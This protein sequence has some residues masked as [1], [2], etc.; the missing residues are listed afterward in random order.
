MQMPAP[1]ERRTPPAIDDTAT[2]LAQLQAKVQQQEQ[3]LAELKAQVV[4]LQQ[5]PAATPALPAAAP[6]TATPA[7]TW[8]ARLTHVLGRFGKLE[9]VLAG[10]AILVYAISRFTQISSFPL[11]FFADEALEVV[12]AQELLQRGFRDEKGGLLPVFFNAYGFQV[13]LVSV[14]FHALTSSL[15]GNSSDVARLTSACVTLTAAIAA[16]LITKLILKLRYWWLVILVLAVTPVWF[17]HSRTAF[18]T[19]TMVSFYSWFLLFYLLYRYRS[20]NFIVPALLFA[21]LTFYSYGNG[22]IVIGITG[23]LLLISDLPYHVKH[24][25]TNLLGLGFLLLLAVP[26]LRWRQQFPEVIENQLRRVDSFMVRPGPWTEKL[27][28]FLENYWRD[29][30]N[31]DYW[32]NPAVSEN[33]RHLL[34]GYAH[35]PV[36]ALPFYL[37]G[38]AWS[39]W[40]MA[41][42]RRSPL[43]AAH[44]AIII[45][46]LAAPVGV[47]LTSPGVTRS[48]MFVLPAAL[49]ITLGIELVLVWLTRFL[50]GKQHEANPAWLTPVASIALCAMLSAATLGMLR[51][52]LA[53]GPLWYS[54]YGLYGVQWGAQ[55]IFAEVK[56]RLKQ[57]PD[58]IYLLTPNWA[59][60]TDVFLRFFVPNEPRVHMQ[61]V[62]PYVLYLRTELNDNMV[63][64]ITPAERKL[65]ESSGKFKPLQIEGHIAYPDGSDGFYFARLQYADNAP[66]VFQADLEERKRPI[67]ETVV[68]RGEALTIAHSKLDAGQLSDL[69]D[70]NPHTLMR[71]M[72]ANPLLIDIAFPAPRKL[73]GLMLT[74]ATMNMLL[75]AEVYVEGQ[76]QPLLFTKEAKD[77]PPDPDVLWPMD[78]ITGPVTRVVLQ[79]QDLNRPEPTNIHIRELQFL[80]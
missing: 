16:G 17:L 73:A 72:E 37:I 6:S 64:M 30:I 71:G 79:I 5:A 62:D 14:Y 57:N 13:P 9:W 19:A 52:A 27:R 59:N 1:E 12:L 34:K 63:F 70:N 47:A 60:G 54:D 58:D 10:I 20:P 23:L 32:F 25:R 61:T 29:G 21:A 7:P 48:L 43:A 53:N 2:L 26:Y 77:L 4:A 31:V 36:L 8:Q 66:A 3:Q 38:I 33:P 18:E 24:W 68:V 42:F 46:T 40:H 50:G 45:A 15:F 56:Q 80:E 75:R 67:T 65:V 74:T 51:D 35:L 41:F 76:N 55:R 78:G 69:F 11:Y 28:I 44:R 49:F 39:L 22:Q